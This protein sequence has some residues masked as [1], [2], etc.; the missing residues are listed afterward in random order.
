MYTAGLTFFT[1]INREV[2]TNAKNLNI[3]ITFRKLFEKIF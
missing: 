3:K 1:L 2:E